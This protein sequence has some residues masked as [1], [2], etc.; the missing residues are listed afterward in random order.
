MIVLSSLTAAMLALTD[1]QISETEQTN[2]TGLEYKTFDC[3]IPT[4]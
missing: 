2:I 1:Q 4:V 3:F